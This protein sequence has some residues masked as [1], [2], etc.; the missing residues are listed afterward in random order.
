MQHLGYFPKL[1][2]PFQCKKKKK[3]PVK[4]LSILLQNGPNII[5]LRN[6]K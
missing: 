1:P 5:N 6:I 3:G 2:L 4:N